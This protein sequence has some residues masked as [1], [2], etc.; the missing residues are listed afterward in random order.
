MNITVEKMNKSHISEIAEI[1]RECFSTPWSEN[2]LFE[3]LENP[4]AHFYCAVSDGKV[5]GYGGM[6]SVVGE[7]Y[8]DNIAVTCSY[9][10]MGVATKILQ[11]LVET[12]EYENGEFISLEVR[13]SNDAAIKLYE[14]NGFCK[15]GV[16]RNFYQ[17]PSENAII[18]T[19][20]IEK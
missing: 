4:N 5:I 12:A 2:S 10:K 9:R 17:K 19:K 20:E 1:E 11:K 14:K 3:E 18:M 16:R 13:E 7:N 8:I 15:V 6:H